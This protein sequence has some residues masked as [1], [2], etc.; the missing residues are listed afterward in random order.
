MEISDSN[1]F[2]SQPSQ[3]DSNNITTP[4]VNVATTRIL[5]SVA[6]PKHHSDGMENYIKLL[7]DKLLSK[8]AVL[9]SHSTI[10][11]T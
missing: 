3:F 5:N 10:V 2:D 7:Q 1:D 6:T 8:I 9:K 11:L 4:I